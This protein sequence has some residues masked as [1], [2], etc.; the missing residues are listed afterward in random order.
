MYLKYLN[1]AAAIIKAMRVLE[2]AVEMWTVK[3]QIASNMY[4]IITF[5]KLN[6]LIPWRKIHSRQQGR[7]CDKPADVI[8]ELYELNLPVHRLKYQPNP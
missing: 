8:P 7:A 4:M 5:L 6:L 1:I 2:A 3:M